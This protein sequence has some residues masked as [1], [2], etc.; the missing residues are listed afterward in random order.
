MKLPVTVVVLTKNEERGLPACLASITPHTDDCIILDSGSDDGTVAVARA[1]GVCVYANRFSGFGDQRN[2]AI[3]HIPHRYNWVLHLDADERMTPAFAAEISTILANDPQEA[4]FFVPSKLML[5]DSWLRYSSGY[6]VYQ[7]RLFHRERLRFVNYGHG[8]REVTGGR[9][10]TM[11]EPYLHYALSKG[12]EAWFEKHARYAASEAIFSDESGGRHGLK[13]AQFL[14]SNAVARRRV[15]KRF[16]RNLPARGTLR[17]LDMLILKRGLLDG[18]SGILY[19]RMMANYENMTAIYRMGSSMGVAIK[20]SEA[21][22]PGE[23]T[24]AASPQ[25]EAA[26]RSTPLVPQGSSLQS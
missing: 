13:W 19:A 26:P 24:E 17:L 23:T 2:W 12:L 25:Q 22:V 8:Q 1:A 18:P 16:S 20:P 4:G 7:V 3:D 11:K 14:L 15:L 6:P 21:A 5:G 10:G 9:L